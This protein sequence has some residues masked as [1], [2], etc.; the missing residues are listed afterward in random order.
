VRPTPDSLRAAGINLRD[1]LT[2]GRLADLRRMPSSIVDDTPLR[3][4]HRYVPMVATA[5]S[6]P[7]LLV[8]P[9][10]APAFAFDLRRGGSLVEHLVAAGRPTYLVDYGPIRVEDTALGLEFWVDDVLP[11][12]IRAVAKDA[13]DDVALVGWC[14]GGIFSLLATAADPGLP[15]RS[16]TAIASPFDVSAVPLVAPLRPLAA[17]AGGPVSTAL[18]LLNGVP[19]PVTR[20][21]FQLSS[22]DKYVMGPVTILSKLDDRDFLAQVEAVD[23]LMRNM[24]AYPGRLFGQL[25]HQMFRANDLAG[26]YLDLDGRRIE[27]ADIE[28]P[29]MLIGGTDDV[30]APIAAVRRGADLLTGS[31]HVRFEAAPGG[32]LGV[33]TGRR[34]RTTTWT[35]L[36][37]FLSSTAA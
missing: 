11:H 4:V 8:P 32:H 3:V 35:Y 10:A 5:G 7:V 30:L 23:H 26:G 24:Y 17:I 27:L 9:L 36:D 33:L 21:A 37:A 6:R 19:A 16:V 22:F 18:R 25:Y 1:K 14:L 2:H 31:P 28:V 29:A 13:G 12:A 34:A 15:V 20:W